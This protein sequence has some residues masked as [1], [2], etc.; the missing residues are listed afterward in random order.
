ML[1]GRCPHFLVC[2]SM[3]FGLHPSTQCSR[4][5][6]P[7]SHAA[8]MLWAQACLLLKRAA[9]ASLAAVQNHMPCF[10]AATL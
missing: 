3:T 1:H 8:C 9:A 5:K 6:V 2:Q 7:Q 10:A 4:S